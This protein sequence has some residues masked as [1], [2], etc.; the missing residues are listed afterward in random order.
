[1]RKTFEIQGWRLRIFKSFS[2]SLEHFFLTV[3]QNNFGNKIPFLSFADAAHSPF[4][5]MYFSQTKALAT[6]FL[7]NWS[8]NKVTHMC[9]GHRHRNQFCVYF[10]FFYKLSVVWKIKNQHTRCITQWV[11]L[12]SN[13]SIKDF[14]TPS[15]S[16]RLF[17]NESFNPGLFNHGFF[18]HGVEKFMVEKSGVGKSGVLI[19]PF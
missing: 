2:R 9:F 4:D 13:I 1:M 14:L 8:A 10:S 7:W 12:F 18:N 19:S 6:M 5:F 17:N 11:E 3:D 16:P 15:F